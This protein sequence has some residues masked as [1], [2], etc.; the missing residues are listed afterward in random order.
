MKICVLQCS[1]E[2]ASSSATIGLEPD[3]CVAPLLPE[4]E[5]VLVGLRKATISLDISRLA[6][7]GYDLF[8]NLCDGMMDE[9]LAGVETSIALAR[10]RCVF[11][12]ANPRFFEKSRLSQKMAAESVGVHFPAFAMVNSLEDMRWCDGLRFPLLVKH[13]QVSAWGGR[14]KLL[15]PLVALVRLFLSDS[16]TTVWALNAHLG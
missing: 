1:Y 2:G 9:D 6:R 14:R 5:V 11:I 12:G 7:Q 16:L 15:E 3:R 8:I 13:P 4:H 10:E